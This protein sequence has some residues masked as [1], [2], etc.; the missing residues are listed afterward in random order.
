ML[1]MIR[2]I[3]E[4]EPE[5]AGRKKVYFPPVTGEEFFRMVPNGSHDLGGLRI[6]PEAQLVVT[7][8]RVKWVG[9]RVGETPKYPASH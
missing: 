5:K 2:K 9:A 1:D 7:V 4:E 3:L 8:S 6:L